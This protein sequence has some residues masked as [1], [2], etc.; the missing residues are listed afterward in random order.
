[1]T[2]NLVTLDSDT[3]LASSDSCDDSDTEYYNYELHHYFMYLDTGI[4]SNYYEP[5]VP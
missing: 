4:S 1:M 2:K 5:Y 3:F